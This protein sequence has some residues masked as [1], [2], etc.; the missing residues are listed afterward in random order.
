MEKEIADLESIL[1]KYRDSHPNLSLLWSKYLKNKLDD[2]KKVIHECKIA[3]NK[4]DTITD[5]TPMNIMTLY[6][7]TDRERP[8]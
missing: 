8:T 1:L 2:L 3:M 7:L 4:I 5:L 6:I